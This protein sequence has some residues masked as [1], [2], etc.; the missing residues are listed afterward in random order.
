M[1]AAAD[2]RIFFVGPGQ[3]VGLGTSVHQSL[4][5]LLARNLKPYVE[6][7]LGSLHFELVQYE[8]SAL[9]RSSKP[10]HV[11]I[12]VEVDRTASLDLGL[13]PSGRNSEARAAG[14]PARP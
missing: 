7:H 14:A 9:D 4:Y 10:A 3:G 2:F 5:L 11:G 6:K 1:L 8:L 12:T 13:S